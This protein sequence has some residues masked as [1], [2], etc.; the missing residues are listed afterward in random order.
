MKKII[1]EK[2][3]F[4]K[5]FRDYIKWNVVAISLFLIA[6]IIGFFVDAWG[7]YWIVPILFLIFKLMTIRY[8]VLFF[9]A[10]KDL[11]QNSVKES[12]IC[13]HTVIRDKKFTLNSRGVEVGDEKCLLIGSDGSEYRVSANTGLAIELRPIKYYQNAKV[14]VQYLARSRIVTKLEIEEYNLLAIRIVKD[15]GTSN[16]QSQGKR[17]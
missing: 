17:K 13:V 1:I 12:S 10:I 4:Y 11:K 8:D 14:M 15:F 7:K 5:Y 2:A 6:F 16:R 9:T 3:M